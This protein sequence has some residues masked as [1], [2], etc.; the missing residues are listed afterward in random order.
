[1]LVFPR[2]PQVREEEEGWAAGGAADVPLGGTGGNGA[3][4]WA[5]QAPVL[6]F[7]LDGPLA[8]YWRISRAGRRC[9]RR[10]RARL[11]VVRSDGS[12]IASND[13][14]RQHRSMLTG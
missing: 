9:R 4:G 1:M 13:G 2:P 7:S 3:G 11:S 8:S 10:W 12:A 6:S 14:A 5:E